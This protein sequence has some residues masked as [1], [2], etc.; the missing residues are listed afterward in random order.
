MWAD[1]AHKFAHLDTRVDTQTD[2]T[3]NEGGE[4][5]GRVGGLRV[6]DEMS[7]M[8]E[9]KIKKEGRKK[10]REL[11]KCKEK[12]EEETDLLTMTS[13]EG[14][15]MKDAGK[16]DSAEEKDTTGGGS[17]DIQGTEV[18]TNFGGGGCANIRGS[19]KHMAG[20]EAVGGDTQIQKDS[21]AT[22]ENTGV[23]KGEAPNIHAETGRE[24]GKEG[25]EQKEGREGEPEEDE[26]LARELARTVQLGV[27]V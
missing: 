12:V 17:A 4:G 1:V 15:E 11:Q 3:K 18:D 9:E 16:V 2:E 5:G 25:K 6:K 24:E 10:V 19:E 23:E 27:Y 8:E 21:H 26:R 14:P 22:T 20:D 13:M 7:A